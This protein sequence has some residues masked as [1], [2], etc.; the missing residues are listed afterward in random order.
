[1]HLRRLS[2]S[3]KAPSG[4]TQEG[5]NLYRSK[6]H[7][8]LR[9]GVTALDTGGYDGGTIVTVQ[10]G[11][12]TVVEAKF[13]NMGLDQDELSDLL[14]DVE[15]VCGRVASE[16]DSYLGDM[17]EENLVAMVLSPDDSRAKRIRRDVK[18]LQAEFDSLL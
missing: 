13:S 12:T 17:S 16:L 6:R 2:E 3:V 4:W 15:D 14:A 9:V 18:R 1:M 11:R 5:R 7:P 10:L 8:L